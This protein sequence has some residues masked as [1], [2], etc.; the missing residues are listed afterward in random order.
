M[1]SVLEQCQRD[2][3]SSSPLIQSL[4]SHHDPHL[5]QDDPNKHTHE[6]SQAKSYWAFVKLVTDTLD[7]HWEK[8]VTQSHPFT[9]SSVL[10]RYTCQSWRTLGRNRWKERRWQSSL[11]SNEYTKRSE[12]LSVL[13]WQLTHRWPHLSAGSLQPG[14]TWSTLREKKKCF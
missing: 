12:V 1:E 13:P 5:Y 6:P 8:W 9:D 14:G 2:I 11:F 10:T 7:V 4:R 3:S